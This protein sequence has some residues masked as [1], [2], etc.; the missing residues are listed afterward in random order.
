[1]KKQN[2]RGKSGDAAEKIIQRTWG[3]MPVIDATHELRVFI[4]PEDVAKATP[5]DTAHCV[6]A[7]ACQR[8]FLAKKVL[9]LR[10]MAYVELPSQDGEHHVERF[11]LPT[12]MRRLVAQFDRGEKIIPEAGFVLRPPPPSGTF[13][14]KRRTRAASK[15]RQKLLGSMEV[16]QEVVRENTPT[17]KKKRAGGPHLI[18]MDVRNGTG[19]IHFTAKKAKR[20]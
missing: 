15:A 14:E 19:T 6:F 11:I 18:D 10:T 7:Q 12:E 20:R 9:F 5:K 13:E 4:L 3:D 8:T 2:Q 1:M 16:V 17:R